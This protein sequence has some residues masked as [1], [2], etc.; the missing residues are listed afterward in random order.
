MMRY[1]SW[2]SCYTETILNLCKCLCMWAPCDSEDKL[3]NLFHFANVVSRGLPVVPSGITGGDRILLSNMKGKRLLM[4]EASE[5]PAELDVFFLLYYY[6]ITYSFNLF[7]FLIL[8]IVLADILSHFG[9][10]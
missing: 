5:P 3:N 9:T 6:T 8:D 2:G 10:L 1:C 7:L 4:T